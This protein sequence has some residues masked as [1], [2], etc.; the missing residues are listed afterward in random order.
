MKASMSI[1][2]TTLSMQSEGEHAIPHRRVQTQERTLIT[3]AV[4]Q[5]CYEL[6]QYIAL[7][8]NICTAEP[9]GHKTMFQLSFVEASLKIAHFTNDA[10]LCNKM[11]VKICKQ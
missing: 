10:M 6:H 4:K 2:F 7:H 3:R 5:R 8:S 11:Q 1:A 9:K